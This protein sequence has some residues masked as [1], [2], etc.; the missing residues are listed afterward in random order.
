MA[1]LR[2]PD[3]CLVE[4]LSYC[5]GDR[6]ILYSAA[7]AHSRL[8]QAA[9]VVDLSSITANV[10]QQQLD[11]LVEVYLWRH[12]QRIDSLSLLGD[13]QPARGQ[14]PSVLLNRL[15][16]CVHLQLAS[17]TCERLRIQLLPEAATAT[18]WQCLATAGAF[19]AC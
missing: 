18:P 12:G 17:L 10:N 13:L 1:L 3:P 2:L 15:P 6:R 5:A 19:W 8:H 9:A 7:R 16:I 14:H 11:S 4:V